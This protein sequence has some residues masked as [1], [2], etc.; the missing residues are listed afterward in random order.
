MESPRDRGSVAA[1]RRINLP[2]RKLRNSTESLL[3]S[4]RPQRN[5]RSSVESWMYSLRHSLSRAR[6]FSPRGWTAPF[7]DTGNGMS[8]SSWYFAWIISRCKRCV[9]AAE[10]PSIKLLIVFVASRK[11]AMPNC[12]TM[13]C[14]SS[15][16]LLF[17]FSKASSASFCRASTAFF[18]ATAASE[19]SSPTIT[20]LCGLTSNGPRCRPMK[21]SSAAKDGEGATAAPAAAATLS[22]SCRRCALV[23]VASRGGAT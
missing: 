20:A 17:N 21:G 6:R 4:V 10:G 9:P 12:V 23:D 5:L 16:A 15:C 18:A 7:F 1:R 8:S 2:H 19:V 14:K 11:S 13:Y 3:Y 22:M